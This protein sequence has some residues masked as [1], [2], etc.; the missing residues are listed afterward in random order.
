MKC[1]ISQW[2]AR[3]NKSNNGATYN[4]WKNLIINAINCDA[5]DKN[6]AIDYTPTN[7]TIKAKKQL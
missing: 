2:N 3:T 7:D 5:K 6:R 1:C 4:K